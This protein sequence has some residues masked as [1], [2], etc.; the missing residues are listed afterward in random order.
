VIKIDRAALPKLSLGDSS[1]L[2][3]GQIVM[4]FGNPLGLEG[5]VSMG[6]VSSTARQL[7]LDDPMTYVQTDAPINPG[8]SGGPLVDAEG[9]VVGINTFILT[10][11]GGSEGIGF[12]VPSNLVRS[13]YEQIIKDGHVHRGQI[14]IVA[15]TITPAIAKGLGLGQDWG[16]IASDVI[17]DGPADKAGLKSGDIIV[18]L[19]GREMDDARQLETLL[20][21]QPLTAIVDLTVTRDGQPLKFSMPVIERDDD[22]QR[23][24]DM[25]DPTK[26]LVP[27]LGILGISI[28][29]RITEMLPDLRNSYGVVVAARGGDTPYTGDTLQLGDVIYSVNTEPVASVE[30]LRAFVDALKDTD[31]LVL[32]VERE[33]KLLYIAMTI[34]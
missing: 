31:P 7:K 6:I 16:V 25:V 22:P 5:S 30:A 4:A 20:Y 33:G 14:G 13:S 10:Q 1:Q 23:F 21:Q 19:G 29:K 2:R 24:A 28:D 18:T 11:S 32:Q 12:A 17:P 8:N 15:Q 27:K 3:Q 34:E 26:N 9:H